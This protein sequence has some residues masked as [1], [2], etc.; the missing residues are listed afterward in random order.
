MNWKALCLIAV[1]TLTVGLNACSEPATTT[2]PSGTKSPDAM[3][4]P[5]ATKSPDAM[6]SPAATKSP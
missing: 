5:A 6:K 3:K 2:T 4:S 1:S